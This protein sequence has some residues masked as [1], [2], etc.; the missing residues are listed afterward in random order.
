MQKYLVA[1][2]LVLGASPALASEFYVAQNP[3]TKD[4]KIVNT[5]PDGTTMTMVGPSSYVT[6]EEAKAAKKA[7]PECRKAID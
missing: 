2:I 4:C 5:K 6:R 3:S 7:A 1:A